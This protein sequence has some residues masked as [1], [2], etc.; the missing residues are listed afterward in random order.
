MSDD[1][2][3]AD[4]PRDGVRAGEGRSDG[5]AEVLSEVGAAVWR[6]AVPRSGARTS[7]A[8]RSVVQRAAKGGID[9]VLFLAPTAPWLETAESIGA[10][11]AIR[12]RSDSGR[13]LLGA[14]HEEDAERLRLAGLAVM[15]TEGSSA[16]VLARGVVAH[17]DSGKTALVTDAGRLEVRSGGVVV[18]ERFIPLSR[19]AT[20]VIEAL[21]LAGGRVL[22]RAE[23]GRVLPGGQRSGRAVE[24]AVARLRESLD[25]I[26]LVQTVVKRGY[27]LAVTE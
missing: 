18:D 9:A 26:D 17:Y 10:L 6:V 27:R 11:E 12:R 3:S 7:A 23:I 14:L 2:R 25:G 24:V 20:G 21:F 16:A 1:A 4:P 22:S 13:L 19:G 15:H 8:L 5:L